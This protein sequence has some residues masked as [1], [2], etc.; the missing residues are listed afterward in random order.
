M[1]GMTPIFMASQSGHVASVHIKA[2]ANVNLA[3]ND[4]AAPMLM[5]Y[6]TRTDEAEVIIKAGAD[7]DHLGKIAGIM[8]P[9]FMA[10]QNGHRH[11]CG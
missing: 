1:S 11:E 2:G 10:S 4:G 3:R 9:I 5:A 7:V 8:T 6:R